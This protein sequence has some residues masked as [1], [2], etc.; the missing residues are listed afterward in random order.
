[1]KAVLKPRIN[2]DDRTALETVIPLPA[3]FVLFIDPSSACNFRC[4]FCPTGDHELIRST[5][6]YQGVLSFELFKK[7][8]DDLKD[9]EKPIKVLRLYKDGEPLLNKNFAKMVRYAKDSGHVPYVDTTT[10]GFYLTHEKSLEI[11]DCGLDRINISVDGLS[12]ADFM[13]YT[14][15]KVDFTKFVDNIKFLYDNKKDL[16]IFI[17]MPG[18]FLTDV[19]K[20]FFFDTF[21]DI[22]DRIS[23]ENFTPCWPVFDVEERMGIDITTGIYNNPIVDIKTCPYIFYSVSVNADGLV[24]LCYLD[25]ARKLLVGDVRTQSLREIWEGDE[26]FNHRIAHLRGKRKENP[27]CAECGQLSHC[28]ADNIDPYAGMLADK[29]IELRKTTPRFMTT[30]QG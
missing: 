30:T 11:I 17:K 1:M 21:G 2:L 13:R 3:P 18:D 22:C 26:I 28:L 19:D 23:L 29:L 16:E 12:D 25:W 24:S 9:F 8:I 14:K 15:T 4:T 10:N 6:R 5:G 7:I 27:V 20:Q